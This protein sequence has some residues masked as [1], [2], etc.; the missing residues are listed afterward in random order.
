MF[1]PPGHAKTRV[2]KSSVTMHEVRF[3]L[4]CY[5]SSP[6]ASRV[7]LTNR[8]RISCHQLLQ[9]QRDRKESIRL[10]LCDF[11]VNL[12]IAQLNKSPYHSSELPAG[13]YLG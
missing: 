12:F 5:L 11:N 10:G 1:T 13:P 6:V 9:R 8:R 2:D 4:L 7:P 3:G